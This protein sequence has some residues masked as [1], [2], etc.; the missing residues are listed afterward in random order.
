MCTVS[1]IGDHYSDKFRKL[2]YQWIPRDPL[3]PG[4]RPVDHP[5]RAEFDALKRE[6][7]EMK[8]L[9]IR[10]KEYDERN[11]EPDCEM[12]EKV[13]L[14]K[15]VAKIVGVDLSEVFDHPTKEGE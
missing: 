11:G 14:L 13:A 6:V 12:D 1:M 9:L 5:T 3:H 2:E 15:Q 8:A 4:A 10:A 7:E